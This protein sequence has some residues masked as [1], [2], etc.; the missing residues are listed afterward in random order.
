MEHSVNILTFNIPGTLFANISLN[1]RW[2]FFRIFQEYIMGM[3]HEH[4]FGRWGITAL[5]GYAQNILENATKPSHILN[6]CVLL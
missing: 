4:I 3:F 1:F 2:N 5:A 6:I